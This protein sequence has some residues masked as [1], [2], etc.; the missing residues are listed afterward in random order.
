MQYAI[1]NP[2]VATQTDAL[3]G[4]TSIKHGIHSKNIFVLML[5]VCGGLAVCQATPPTPENPRPG[6]FVVAP[7]DRPLIRR[8]GQ[9][10]VLENDVGCKLAIWEEDGRYGLGTFYLNGLALGSPIKTFLTEA[11]TGNNTRD[12]FQRLWPGQWT[13]HFRPTKY[14]IVQNGPAQGVIK[15]SG[16]EGKFEGEVTITFSRRH[17][18]Y[19]LDYDIMPS[20]AITHPVFVSA[21]LWPD[22][23][24][25]VQ[26]PFE[27]P[28]KPPFNSDWIIHPTRSTVPLM[29]ACQEL[30]GRACFVGVGYRLD[31]DYQN[32]RLEYN[33]A[34]TAPFQMFYISPHASGWL[35]GPTHDYKPQHYKLGVVISTAATQYDCMAGYRLQSGY[36]ISPTG[37]RPLDAAVAGVMEMYK[38]CQSYVPLPPHTN[39]AYRQQINP[40]NGRPV[41]KGY[42]LY[43][44]IGVNVQLAY[45][46]YLYWQKHPA[47]SWA[48]DRAINMANFFVETQA[49]TGA[50]PTLW[51]TKEKRFR[52]YEKR[53]DQAGYHYATCQQAMGAYHLYRLYLARKT[54]EKEA[55][56]PWKTAAIRAMDDL[57]NKVAPDG[58]LGRNYDKQGKFDTACAADWPL[59][60]LDYI[61]AQTGQKKYADARER[62]EGWVYKTFI[63]PNHWFGWSSDNGW[64]RSEIPPPWNVDCLNA[65]TLATYCAHRHMRTDDPKY[66]QWS[67]HI[68]AYNWLATI[69]L[70]FPEFKHVTKGLVR[71]QE[72]YLT[73]DLPFRTCLYIDCLPYLTA[74][75]GDRFFF[76]YYKLMIQ[77]QLAYQ[78]QAP[79][80]QSFNI[81]LWPDASGANPSD[82]LGEEKV[83]YIV[84]FCS[85]FLE[86]VTSPNAY[87]YVGGPDWGAGL[88]YELTFTP[89][90]DPKGPCVISSSS[91]LA[92]ARWNAQ[93]R[94]LEVTLSGYTGD[95]G[96][97][98]VGW[99]PG[100]YVAAEI[101]PQ[102]D[103]RSIPKEKIHS[104]RRGDREALAIDYVLQKVPTRIDIVFPTVSE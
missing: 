66:L 100:R 2:L 58:F 71:E 31:Q 90:F 12:T 87:R 79:N 20:D 36:D 77:T 55:I 26:F 16:R 88:D 4:G 3:P 95:S 15:F 45:Q 61:A 17:A 86:S 92:D 104:A 84:E 41:D 18:G 38:T 85:L 7:Q 96:Q 56:E 78:N 46:L 64:W 19:R 70:Q 81:G 103:G 50:V 54:R 62:L 34:A 52:A 63:G 27:N 68:V 23:M 22:K 49:D 83:N 93:T 72:F 25:F 82:E 6:A 10:I 40:Q 59:V 13:P 53:I 9:Q 37:G 8:D 14:E 102:I 98:V 43:V 30:E 101:R 1:V 91:Q 29:I 76:D 65:F 99:Q 69:P 5:G 57:A 39:M 89:Q 97:L 11:N 80:L 47:E 21:P 48:R 44:P 35:G 75:T 51:D 42:G 94:T 28:I 60:A 74:V 67:T 24:Q 32:G 73:Y 33:A